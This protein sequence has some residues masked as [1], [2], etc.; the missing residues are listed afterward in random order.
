MAQY[1]TD[2]SEYTTGQQPSD[3]T[4]RFVS[5]IEWLVEEDVSGTGG[6]LIRGSTGSGS[7][8]NGLSWDAI[9]SDADRA[10]TQ[11]FMRV[12]FPVSV[13]NA[14]VLTMSRASDPAPGANM[15]R[16]GLR[17]YN[18]EISL[19]SYVDGSYSGFGDAIGPNSVGTFYNILTETR[20]SN[21]KI[22]VWIDGNS[23][24]TLWDLEATDFGL[25]AAGWIGIFRFRPDAVDIDFYGVGTGADDAPRTVSSPTPT[26][27][28]PTAS[29]DG[30]TGY[31]GTIS[32]NTGSGT[33]YHVVTGSATT[34]SIAQVKAGLD[35]SGAAATVAGSQSVSAVGSQSVS[36]SGL[37]TGNTYYIHYVQNANSQDSA[38]VSSS[39][40]TPQAVPVG[41]LIPT[42]LTVTNI[43]ATSATLSWDA[44]V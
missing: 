18:T 10:D 32:T 21:H 36:G 14:E 25:S 42:N 40:F 44:G 38:V 2:F 37:T 13:S 7:S 29:A 5:D 34:P 41:P 43:T 33:L 19:A 8:R 28:S 24:P 23:E 31:T 27:T 39:G 6:R 11:I 20:G 9:D 4:K 15:Y 30:E 12:R 1:G 3:W 35:D 22:K 26:L 17:P 16:H